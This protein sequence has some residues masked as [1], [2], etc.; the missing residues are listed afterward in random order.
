MN[1]LDQV[2]E[3]IESVSGTRKRTEKVQL[4]KTLE[5][6]AEKLYKRLATL[7]LDPYRTFGVKPKKKLVTIETAAISYSAAESWNAFQGLAKG[8]AKRSLTG[9]AAAEAIEDFFARTPPEYRPLYFNVLNKKL[10]TGLAA[11]TINSVHEGL[12]PEFEVQ[13]ADTLE[14]DFPGPLLVE[15]KMDG[16]RALI[17]ADPSNPVVLSRKGLELPKL[18]PFAEFL[19]KAAPGH[20]FDGEAFAENWQ[21]TITAVKNMTVDDANATKIYLFDLIPISAFHQ[22]RFEQPQHK[23]KKDLKEILRETGNLGGMLRYTPHRV[24]K[25]R[26]DLQ[27]CYTEFLVHGFEGAVAK[28]PHGIWIPG[29]KG[30]GKAWWKFKEEHTEDYEIIG[31][32]EGKNQFEGSLGGIYIDVDGV[33]VKVGTGFKATK[34]DPLDR[35]ALWRMRDDLIGKTA[36]V[37]YQEKTPDGSLRNPRIKRIRDD[38]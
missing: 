21:S 23:R 25:N 35:R 2:L 16:L 11:K 30:R 36:E 24:A 1:P 13:L 31:T 5:G 20:V 7:A 15:P 4:L 17:F 22:K 6:D 8:L 37:S 27:D 9:N 33:S 38:K 19:A 3:V 34:G 14:G 18:R 28:D 29:S 26:S 10:A 12:I 32:F